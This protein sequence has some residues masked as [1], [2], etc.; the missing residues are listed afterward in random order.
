MI[1]RARL[2]RGQVV[3]RS[4]CIAEE[5]DG[6]P[7]AFEPLRNDNTAVYGDSCRSDV[8]RLYC[9]MKREQPNRSAPAR[10]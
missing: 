9:H 1:E 8:Y 6:R 3:G 5:T 2:I 7:K 4:L 10:N